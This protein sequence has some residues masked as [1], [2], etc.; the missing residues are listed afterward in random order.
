MAWWRLAPFVIAVARWLG[1]IGWP[2]R[3]DRRQGFDIDVGGWSMN[4]LVGI[5][6][7]LAHGYFDRSD[8]VGETL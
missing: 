3:K 5:L 2:G 1:L 8:T 6:S 7:R 4:A